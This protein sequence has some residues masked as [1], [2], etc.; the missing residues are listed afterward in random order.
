[1]SRDSK[2]SRKRLLSYLPTSGSKRA[3]QLPWRIPQAISLMSSE[4]LDG[5]LCVVLVPE[6]RRGRRQPHALSETHVFSQYKSFITSVWPEKQNPGEGP[7]SGPGGVGAST[8]NL[9]V[10]NRPKSFPR[11]VKARA[12]DGAGNISVLTCCAPPPSVLPPPLCDFCA[13]H[14]HHSLPLAL[15]PT[16]TC[17]DVS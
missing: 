1:M 15:S 3:L 7:E 5:F 8:K 16:G 14:Q 4:P 12:F 2:A 13:V 10:G 11:G 9:R 17:K 6:A